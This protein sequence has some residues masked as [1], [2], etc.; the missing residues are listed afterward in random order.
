[1]LIPCDRVGL[2]AVCLSSVWGVGQEQMQC[3]F[4][5]CGAEGGGGRE[6]SAGGRRLLRGGGHEA[7]AVM[8]APGVPV[9]ASTN[10]GGHA[11]ACV[12]V[13]ARSW[14][15]CGRWTVCMMTV[16]LEAAGAGPLPTPSR[17]PPHPQRAEECCVASAP[18]ASPARRSRA[19]PPACARR[20]PAPAWWRPCAARMPPPTATSASCSG[21]SAASRGASACCAGGPAVSAGRGL[22]EG[23]AEGRGLW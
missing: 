21:R 4:H 3:P 6:G 20:A 17:L 16:G 10:M 9:S 22:G 18:S 7:L 13:R 8:G 11:C 2:G 14:Q 1:M 23:D 5:S 19:E 15:V 12:T